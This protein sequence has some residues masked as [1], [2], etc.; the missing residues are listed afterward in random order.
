[1]FKLK[2]FELGAGQSVTISREQQV[3]NFT[4]RVHYA[5]FHAVDVLINGECLGRSGFDLKA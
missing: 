4:T 3:R 1:M 5:G 2:T